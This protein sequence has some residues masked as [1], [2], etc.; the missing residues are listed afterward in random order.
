MLQKVFQW[1]A[2]GIAPN[3]VVQDVPPPV[4]EG[5]LETATIHALE[6]VQ[7]HVLEDV[8]DIAIILVKEDV[9]VRH[10]K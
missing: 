5:V 10:I 1:D 8:Q 4:Q 2:M 6:L 7:M 9:V 3:T